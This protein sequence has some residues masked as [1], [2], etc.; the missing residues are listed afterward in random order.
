M[1]DVFQIFMVGESP[2]ICFLS[3]S[4]PTEAA[5]PSQWWFLQALPRLLNA[6]ISQCLPPSS[7][8]TAMMI[9]PS[10]NYSNCL[11]LGVVNLRLLPLVL[12]NHRAEVCPS[13]D[14]C[15]KSRKQPVAVV[16]KAMP[17][18]MEMNRWERLRDCGG[19]GLSPMS[20]RPIL[21]FMPCLWSAIASSLRHF[22]ISFR[23]ASHSL[24]SS[25]LCSAPGMTPFPLLRTPPRRLF[26]HLPAENTG[27]SAGREV[28]TSVCGGASGKN[29]GGKG[30][31]LQGD[32][33]S[34]LC[35]LSGEGEG[36]AHQVGR[37]YKA[38]MGGG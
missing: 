30:E 29:A 32:G 31:V 13:A 19:Q 28:E 33:S 15:G 3:C 9:V 7:P 6:V 35:C 17:I 5:I 26:Y 4:W 34:L 12:T 16:R 10:K 36:G 23:E 20:V 25:A 1:L 21:S 38:N 18:R 8:T 27:C 22:W 37:A 24:P 14:I 2:L 11:R